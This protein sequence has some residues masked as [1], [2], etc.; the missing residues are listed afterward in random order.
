MSTFNCCLRQLD[1]YSKASGMDC[2]NNFCF[3]TVV[4]RSVVKNPNHIVDYETHKE[5]YIRK[6]LSKFLIK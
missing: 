2:G 1:E 6:G 3:H 4:I 5:E